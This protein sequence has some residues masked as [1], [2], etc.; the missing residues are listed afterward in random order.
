MLMDSGADIYQNRL[1]Y[2][3][4]VGFAIE[5]S[6]SPSRHGNNQG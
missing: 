5:I 6:L 2:T 1:F 4:K 3:V